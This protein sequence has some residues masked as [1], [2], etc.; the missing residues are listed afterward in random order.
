VEK[1]STIPFEAMALAIYVFAVLIAWATASDKRSNL[2]LNRVVML[3]PHDAA[4]GELSEQRD[5]IVA[6]WTR[7]QNGTIPQQLECGARALDYRPFLSDDGELY[8]HHGP[9][10]IYKSMRETLQEI[11]EWGRKNP[12][13]LILMSLS[14]C[15]TQRFENAY[16]ADEC[17]EAAVALLNEL[18]I[19]TI[20]DCAAFASM[21]YAD[22]LSHGTILAEFECSYGFWDPSN[23]CYGM[24]NGTEYACYTSP[25]EADNTA[26]PWTHMTNFL[27]S[28]T[29]TVPVDNGVPWGIGGNWQSS[30]QSDVLGTLHNS[31][32]L[33]DE[34]RSE[35]NQWLA[36][37]I[38][39][40]LFKNLN[41][42][43]VDNVC[44]GGIE[45]TDAINEY[46]Y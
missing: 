14:H 19:Y 32:L 13:E 21:T 27:T 45:I 30:A 29:A 7:T 33:Q 11:Q 16:Y 41:L 3:Q 17:R 34:V 40:G 12:S 18:N 6:R 38:R 35:I 42:L 23:T 25:L 31:S 44:D 37:S 43:G 8:A 26:I 5:K 10:V 28:N 46:F 24:Q 36:D 1:E 20:T 9:I 22:A 15:V 2:P 39:A 4:T